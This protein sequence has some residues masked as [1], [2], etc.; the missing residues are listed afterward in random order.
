MLLLHSQLKAPGEGWMEWRVETRE[1]HTHLIQ[2]A[3]F[4]PYGLGGFLYWVFAVSISHL[5]ISRL[6]KKHCAQLGGK[7]TS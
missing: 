1:N 6:N 3:Y 5:C 2:T 7:I 4:T